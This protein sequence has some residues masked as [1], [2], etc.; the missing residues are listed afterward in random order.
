M[1]K[2]E[3][4]KDYLLD[5]EGASRRNN[6]RK[7]LFENLKIDL[8]YKNEE[9]K[10]TK[11][12]KLL[13]KVVEIEEK[14]FGEYKA[15]SA[16]TYRVLEII[17]NLK[18]NKQF[19]DK[20]MSGE[21]KPKDL[22]TMEVKEMFEKEKRKQL[23]KKIENLVNAARSDWDQKHAKVTSGVYKCKICGGDK[24]IQYEIQTRS[25]DESMTLFITC[26]KCKNVWKL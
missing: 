9:D 21:I 10:E 13:K 24:T 7:N 26:V 5:G 1:K 14:I 11:I 20:I 4:P 17:Y 18:E 16:Y 3:F 22:A 6:T 25:A 8:E 23:D 15:D 2:E 12:E 19:R